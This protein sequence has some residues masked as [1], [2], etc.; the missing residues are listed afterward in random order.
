MKI[1]IIGTGKVGRAITSYIVNEGHDLCIIDNNPKVVESLVYKYDIIGICGNGATYD[2]QK[3]AE[4]DKSDLVII[5][6]SSD[7]VNILAALVAK[8]MGAKNTI[9]RIRNQDYYQ[10]V[11]SM[12]KDIGVSMIINPEQEAAN[13]IVQMI[14]FPQALKIENFAKGRINLVEIY[15]GDNSPLV[16]ESLQNIRQKYQFQVLVCAVQRGNDVFIPKGDF[17]IEAKDKIHITASRNEIVKFLS[18]LGIIE[19]KLKSVMIIGGGNISAYLGQRLLKNHYRVKIIEKDEKRCLELSEL[20]PTATIICGDGTDNELLL[21]EGIESTDVVISLIGID[22]ENI[23]SSMYANSL[24]VPKVISKINR[25]NFTRILEENGIASI[26]SP[27]IISA[28]RVLSYVRALANSR[29]S[30]VVT[31]YKLV[32]NEVEA[33]EFAVNENAKCLDIPLKDLKL[34]KG[35]LIAAII[36]NNETKIPEASDCIKVNDSVIV[37]TNNGFLDNLDDILA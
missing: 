19:T 33:L 6:T 36:R 31:L 2:I 8:R 14:D 27:K 30:N 22:E 25:E 34:K 11:N 32:N 12:K 4:V 29:G 26:I 3:K 18:K 28:L 20:M 17:V 21:D 24:G 10:Q 13:E 5:C 35:V 37:V 7:E 16:N 15:I 1:A 9:I 23:I